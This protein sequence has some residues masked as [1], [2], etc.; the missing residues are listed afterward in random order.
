MIDLEPLSDRS[1]VSPQRVPGR[2]PNPHSHSCGSPVEELLRELLER[3]LRV[4]KVD[5]QAGPR[6]LLLRELLRRSSEASHRAQGKTKHKPSRR[7]GVACPVP[8]LWPSSAG[9]A[10]CF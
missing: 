8:L 2:A 4:L 7:P 9:G 3:L 1:A 6:L 10:A 5:L